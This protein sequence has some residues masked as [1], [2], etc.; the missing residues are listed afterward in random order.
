MGAKAAVTNESDALKSGGGVTCV[1]VH[2]DDMAA[3]AVAAMAEASSG[4]V[5]FGYYTSVVL[6]SSTTK[7]SEFVLTL[8]LSIVQG[9]AK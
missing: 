8:R 2:A 9:L 3:D 7:H 5:R 6:L 4:L 1:N